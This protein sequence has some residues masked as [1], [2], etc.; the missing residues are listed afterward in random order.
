ML[1]QMNES[2][3]RLKKDCV[4]LFY[5]HFPDHS[6]PIEETL[7]DVNLLYKGKY[8]CGANVHHLFTSTQ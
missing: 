4:D 7:K 5:L 6:V 1:D 8:S 3:E 2:L